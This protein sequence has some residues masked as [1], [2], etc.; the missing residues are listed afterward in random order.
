MTETIAKAIGWAALFS[1]AFFAHLFFKRLSSRFQGKGR[2]FF[3][4]SHAI[5]PPLSLFSALFSAS[6][7]LETVA[8]SFEWKLDL[9]SLQEL[10]GIGCLTWSLFRWKGLLQRAL[11]AYAALHRET[12]KPGMLESASKALT[13]LILFFSGILL[14]KSFGLDISWLVTFSGIGV[15]GL[16]LASKDLVASLYGGFTI[17]TSRLFTLQDYIELPQKKIAGTVENIG[18]YY[19]T[20][21]DVDKNPIY[22]PN[23]FFAT[24]CV[25]NMSHRTHRL[26]DTS[27]PLNAKDLSAAEEAVQEIRAY[28]AEHPEID[29]KQ[30]LYV[31]M[32]ALTPYSLQLRIKAYTRTIPLDKFN[33]LHH[34]LVTALAELVQK[35]N[36][37]AFFFDPSAR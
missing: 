21:R 14:L 37:A 25:I 33:A 5:L 20:I 8:A 24:E 32:E 10:G 34:L 22:V 6:L 16:A 17:Q 29:A 12:F 4:L 23:A 13:V 11:A 7:L 18:W 3:S 28:L 19:T 2:F 15:A 9:S 36:A 30:P 31:Y 1:G 26:F 35:K 27:L